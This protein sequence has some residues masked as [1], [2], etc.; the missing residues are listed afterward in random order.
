MTNDLSPVT[1]QCMRH[2]IFSHICGT[3]S[4]NQWNPVQS[5][6]TQCRLGGIYIDGSLQ[7][8]LP[9]VDSSCY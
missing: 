7:F 8:S 4:L 1:Q 3:V 2:G 6:D 9:E 5:M